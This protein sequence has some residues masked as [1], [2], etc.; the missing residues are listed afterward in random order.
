MKTSSWKCNHKQRTLPIDERQNLSFGTII[1]FKQETLIISIY[2]I[3][4]ES[5][6]ISLLK[7]LE[8]LSFSFIL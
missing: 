2:L 6:F 3:Y 1:F 7:Q 4:K 8:R 5:A